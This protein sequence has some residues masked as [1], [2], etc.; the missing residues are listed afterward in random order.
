MLP[1]AQRDVADMFLFGMSENDSDLIQ[2]A[3]MDVFRDLP[4]LV[5]DCVDMSQDMQEKL[6]KRLQAANRDAA[7]SFTDRFMKLLQSRHT[8]HLLQILHN[9]PKES[10]AEMAESLVSLTTLKRK[11]S[12]GLETVGGPVDVAVISKGDGFVWMKRKHYFDEK[13]NPTFVSSYFQ[14]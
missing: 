1:F 11:V 14:R 13:M 4:G 2:Q 10:L 8:A 5:A 3:L 7:S 6:R 9:L 12:E